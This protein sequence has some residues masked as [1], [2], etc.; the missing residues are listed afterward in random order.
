[1]SRI[2]GR[3]APPAGLLS[4]ISEDAL[5]AEREAYCSR[6]VR[7]AP[8]SH[9]HG[10][11]GFLSLDNLLGERGDFGVGAKNLRDPRHVHGADMVG[12]HATHEIDIGITGHGNIHA[13]MHRLVH[14]S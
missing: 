2:S 1:M 9:A 3:G 6:L 13:V 14:R 11:L 10:D 8:A 5:P 12:N 4:R 7:C